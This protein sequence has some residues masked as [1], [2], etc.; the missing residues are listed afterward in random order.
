MMIKKLSALLLGLFLFSSLFAQENFNLELVSQTTYASGGNDIWGYVDKN[1]VEY[2]IVGSRASTLLYSLADPAAP[3]LVYEVPGA[4]GTWR[5]MKNVGDYLYITADQGEDGLLIINMTEVDDSISH[6]FY[7]PTFDAGNGTEILRKIHNLYA[8]DRYVYLSGFNDRG[9]VLILDTETDPLAPAIIGFANDAYSHDVYVQDSIMYASEIFLGVLGIYD[10]KDPTNPVLLARQSTTSNF[11]HNAWAS[12]DGN[13]V[14][15]TDERRNGNVDAYDISDL[16]QIKRLDFFRPF[17]PDSAATIPHNTHYF[18]GFLVTS[19]YEDGVIIIDANK[20]DNLVEVAAYD[21]YLGRSGTGS[22]F[23]GCWGVTPYLPSGLVIANDINS[24]FYVLEPTY[25]RA[26]YL[27]GLVLDSLTKEP[28]LGATVEIVSQQAN[29]TMSDVAGIYKTGIAY[30]GDFEVVVRHPEYNTKRVMVN[31]RSAEVTDLTIELS[32]SFISGGVKEA[33]SGAGIPFAKVTVYN[34]ET[35]AFSFAEAD[36]AGNFIIPVQANQDYELYAGSWGYKGMVLTEVSTTSVEP[37][38]L[39]LETGY[40]DDF[41]ADLGWQIVTT[42]TVGEWE[43]GIPNGTVDGNR[44]SNPNEDVEGD[45]GPF[46][47]VT[48]NSGVGLGDQDVDGGSTTLISP[49]MDFS[50]ETIQKFS[51]DV[52]VWWYNCCGNSTPD[53]T[54][55]VSLLTGSEEILLD[56]INGPLS[57]WIELSYEFDRQ[58]ID[59]TSTMQLMITAGDEGQGHIVEAGVDQ[60]RAEVTQLTSNENVIE[61]SF[62]VYPNPAS[63]SIYLTLSKDAQV[64][65]V[66]MM[67]RTLYVKHHKAGLQNIAVSSL[68]A[69]QYALKVINADGQFSSRTWVKQ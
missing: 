52:Q 12:A 16:D 34:T 56:K 20:P 19:W 27:E 62:A 58:D 22:G 37:I 42:A 66:D 24:G 69:G 15:T 13:Y 23:N 46:A 40:E 53:D 30:T 18:N 25:V 29:S 57:T 50:D 67:G 51:I 31:L 36:D 63:S 60:F 14:F 11:T 7:K 8:D 61:E 10:I 9:G 17:R 28:I 44:F 38:E 35:N 64:Q 65:I 39:A 4:F 21:T 2:A 68:L 54:L 45:L 49:F 1:S 41:F 5:D 6:V 59:F 47:Y 26:S 55:Y 48:G 32:Q 33:A 43:L 3:E